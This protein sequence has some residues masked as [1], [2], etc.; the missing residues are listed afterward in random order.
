MM[1][2]LTRSVMGWFEHRHYW[3]PKT[4]MNQIVKPGTSEA[5]GGLLVEDCVCGA[6]R[7][8]EFHPGEAPVVRIALT[9]EPKPST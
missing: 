8:I 4:L 1:S 5:I 9:V 7:T 6:V 3:R 2:S